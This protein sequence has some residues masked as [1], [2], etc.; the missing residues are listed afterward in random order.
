VEIAGRVRVWL[1]TTD[2]GHRILVRGYLEKSGFREVMDK[3]CPPP[4]TR[5]SWSSA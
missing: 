1:A 3:E 4:M 2:N 5:C